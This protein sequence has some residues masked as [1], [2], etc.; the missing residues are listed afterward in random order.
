MAL[1]T[2]SNSEKNM[3]PILYEIGKST[4]KV[5]ATTIHTVEKNS[6]IF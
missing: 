1:L 5:D 2:M 4:E 6:F 3:E